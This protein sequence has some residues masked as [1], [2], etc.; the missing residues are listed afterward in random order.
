MAH[1][2]AKR[3]REGMRSGNTHHI[4]LSGKSHES[5]EELKA[6]FPKLPACFMLRLIL[7]HVLV[8]KPK[9]ERI[10]I[11]ERALRRSD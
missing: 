1:G 5:F 3:K 9:D 11:I 8:D 4:R 2:V 6:E 10:K 7:E